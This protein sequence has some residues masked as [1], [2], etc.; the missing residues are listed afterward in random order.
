MK[1]ESL[2]SHNCHDL[3]DFSNWCLFLAHVRSDDR[4]PNVIFC[5]NLISNES[6]FIV[7]YAVECCTCACKYH[8]SSSFAYKS[9]MQWHQRRLAI[10]QARKVS[11]AC[12][13]RHGLHFRL[14]WKLIG[15]GHN[16]W[17]KISWKRWEIQ[18]WAHLHE[19]PTDFRLAPSH[20]TLDDLKESNINMSR[21]GSLT[22]L[23]ITEVTQSAHGLHFEWPWEVTAIGMCGYTPVRITGA[24][25]CRD[26]PKAIFL[27]SAE[28]ESGRSRISIYVPTN[29]VNIIYT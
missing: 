5:R 24:L 25:V 17:F 7:I 28:A 6:P 10:R 23:Y 22:M 20:L 19:G 29:E 26:R 13:Y 9:I 12:T 14:P 3:L 11:T 8:N 1:R 15:K 16:L 4:I 2:T 27:V 18:G 21:M